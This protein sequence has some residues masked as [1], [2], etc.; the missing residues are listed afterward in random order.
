MND[1]YA[2][3]YLTRAIQSNLLQILKSINRANA[4][5]KLSQFVSAV[6]GGLGTSVATAF[7]DLL[8][9]WAQDLSARS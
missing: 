9:N 7:G 5:T 3:G 1:G 8:I 6:R 2:R 4:K